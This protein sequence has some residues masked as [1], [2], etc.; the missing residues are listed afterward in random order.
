MYATLL[1]QFSVTLHSAQKLLK[2]LD[3]CT[4]QIRQSSS[5][6]HHRT[7]FADVIPVIKNVNNATSQPPK[8]TQ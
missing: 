5:R 6:I 8:P 3:T 2:R 4:W 1:V 7:K